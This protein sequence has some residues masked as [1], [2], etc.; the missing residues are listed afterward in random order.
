[1]LLTCF[2]EISELLFLFLLES[3][4][5]WVSAM[6]LLPVPGELFMQNHEIFRRACACAR[7]SLIMNLA[8][9]GVLEDQAR[10]VPPWVQKWHPTP[11]DRP[12]RVAFSVHGHGAPVQSST[13]GKNGVQKET[14]VSS[15]PEVWGRHAC[16]QEDAVEQA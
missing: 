14:F 6:N 11:S 13:L 9:N 1:M 3:Y 10:G 8:P 15:L 4:M 5:L 2:W 16:A 7:A 12:R